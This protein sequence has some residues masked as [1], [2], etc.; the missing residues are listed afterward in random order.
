MLS[1]DYDNC[2]HTTRV[3]GVCTGCGLCLE[4]VD[5]Q[6]QV[7]VGAHPPHP[8]TPMKF[9]VKSPERINDAAITKILT[10]LG[11]SK[12]KGVVR[13]LL[14]TTKFKSR[15]KKEDRVIVVAYHLLRLSGFPIVISDVLK[16]TSMSKYELLRAHRDTFAY[17]ERSREY[18]RGVFE[19][20][21]D[22]L[23]KKDFEHT[24]SLDGFCRLAEMHRCS[25]PKALCLA[26]FLEL[27]KASTLIL[28]G[29]DEYNIVQVDNIRR[30]LKSK[31][32]E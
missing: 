20:V 3:D 9:I 30:K 23:H 16:F 6:H 4:D 5:L 22:F 19:R 18:L 15:M 26:Y 25:D 32:L 10:A 29:H 11:L 12:Y 27:N 21:D 24:G 31:D 8:H 2:E 17:V 7:A 14:L 28:K 13:N 1:T